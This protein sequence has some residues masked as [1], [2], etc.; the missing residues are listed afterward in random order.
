MDLGIAVHNP[1][2]CQPHGTLSDTN[3]LNHQVQ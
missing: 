1:Y 2:S 3:V